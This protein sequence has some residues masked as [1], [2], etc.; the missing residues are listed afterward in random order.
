MPCP[1]TAPPGEPCRSNCM[2]GFD[3]RNGDAIRVVKGH[4]LPGI[5]G[6][7]QRLQQAVVKCMP[8]FVSRERPDQTV[9]QKIQIP[10]GVEDRI[11]CLTNSS[12]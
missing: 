8:G 2:D 11:L 9:A 4:Y 7:H 10:N 3:E 6:L 5:L 1:A 12:S